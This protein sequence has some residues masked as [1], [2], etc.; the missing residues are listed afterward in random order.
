MYKNQPQMYKWEYSSLQLPDGWTS[1][2]LSSFAMRPY[3]AIRHR[4]KISISSKNN[5]LV[6]IIIVVP[7]LMLDRLQIVKCFEPVTLN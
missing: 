7:S 3:M 2:Y 6:V 1:V 4:Y 5:Q